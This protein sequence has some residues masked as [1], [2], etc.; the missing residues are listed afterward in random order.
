MIWE[1]I[2]KAKA[3]K[4]DLDV[5]W[6]DL[7]NAYGSVPHQMIHLSL[8]MCHVP[9]DISSMLGTYF[10][11][12]HLW[13]ST[14]DFTTNWTRLEVGIAMGCTVSPVLFVLPMQLL[15][16]VTERKSNLVELGRGCQMQSVKA[17]MDDTTIL[18]SKESTTRKLISFMNELIIR[19][20]M[21]F[22][23]RKSRILSLRRGKLNQNFSF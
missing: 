11:G 7:A 18:S 3:R 5:I 22:K 12:F 10:D 6:L 13:F 16:K 4:K 21:K 19:C 8:Q 15:L 1:A 14:K 9:A 2:Q 17:Y 20:R 23:V